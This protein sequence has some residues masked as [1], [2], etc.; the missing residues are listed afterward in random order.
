MKSSVGPKEAYRLFVAD[1]AGTRSRSLALGE[2]VVIGRHSACDV[3]IGQTA[4]G[5]VEAQ[6]GDLAISLR[7]VLLRVSAL[8]DGTPTTDPATRPVVAPAASS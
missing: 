8:D 4:T 1:E 3:V 5:L 7:H 6:A 2:H